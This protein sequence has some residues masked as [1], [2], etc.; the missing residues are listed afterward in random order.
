MEKFSDNCNYSIYKNNGLKDKNMG[1]IKVTKTRSI[2]GRRGRSVS[3]R[4]KKSRKK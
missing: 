4:G 1:K 2:T 3:S